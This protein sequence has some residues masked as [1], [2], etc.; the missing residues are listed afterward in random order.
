MKE[1]KEIW[2]I[3]LSDIVNEKGINHRMCAGYYDS[4]DAAIQAAQDVVKEFIGDERVVEA[5]VY[6]GEHIDE[7]GNICGE[8]YDIYCATNVRPYVS[9]NARLQAGF[10]SIYVNFYAEDPVVPCKLTHYDDK[11]YKSALVVS[12]DEMDKGCD[13]LIVENALSNI[14][15]GEDGDPVDRNAELMDSDIY[16]YCPSDWF[17]LSESE[18]V[19]KVIKTF[20]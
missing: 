12:P 8:P 5:V 16:A 11:P 10:S 2:T 9:A 1:R 20:S 13:W 3:D 14:L 19:K 4:I 6:Q 7:N 18:F 15:I 17:E